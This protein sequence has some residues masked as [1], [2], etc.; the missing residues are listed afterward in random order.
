VVGLFYCT[1]KLGGVFKLIDVNVWLEDEYLANLVSSLE[2]VGFK[3]M[4][5]TAKA[6]KVASRIISYT[7]KSYA[8]GAPIP[9]SP[10][11]IKKPGGGYARSIKVRCL[12]PFNYFIFSDSPVAGFIEHG[13]KELDMKKTH[14]FGRKSRVGK[15]PYGILGKGIPYLIVPFRHG[16]PGSLNA[17]MPEKVY[18]QLRQQIKSGE[19]QLSKV[20]RGRKKEPNWKGELISRRKYTWGSRLTGADLGNLEGLVVLNVSSRKS[21]RSQYFTFRVISAKSPAGS[22]IKPATPAKRITQSVVKNTQGMVN[23]VITAGV[24]RDLGLVG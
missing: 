15:K 1:G 11:R 2:M 3:A 23:E 20:I 6:F 14:P 21:V 7:W 19:F 9:G 18:S 10:Y 8:M 16:I 13:T 24:K 17:P 5:Q 22:W 12:T 4:P